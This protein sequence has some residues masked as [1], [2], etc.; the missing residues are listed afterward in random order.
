MGSPLAPILAHL[1]MSELEN[2]IQ[3]HRGKKPDLFYRYVDDIFMIMHG[4][5]KDIHSFLKFMNKIESSIKFTIEM[6][7]NNKLP[8]LDVMVE[9]TNTELITYVYRKPTDT[10]LYLRW[11][12]NQP[13]N[14]KINLIKCLCIRAKRIC[15]SDALLK[16]QLEYYKRIF[17]ANG[18][19]IN[20]LKKTIRGIELGKNIVKQPINPS[21]KKVFISMPYYGECSLILANKIKKILDHPLKQIVCGFAAR[22][23]ISTLF[24]GTFR[25]QKDMKKVIYRYDC[26]NCNGTYIGQTGR[27][28]EIRKEEH[29]KAFRG[30]GYSRIAEHCMHLNH[31]NNWTDI[32][33]AV[34]SNYIKRTIKESLLMDFVRIKK[35]K[36]VYSQK[37]FILNVF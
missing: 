9:R 7:N 22:T 31:E 36:D 34:E 25:G 19:P 1:F 11:T 4:N 15:S 37:S 28:V 20:V 32:I 33:I 21:I 29:K 12:S 24:S 13:R 5:Q 6:Q 27:G 3:D 35:G 10:G 17:T 2:C 18:Y 26:K 16:Q 23:R 30:R 8:F 14:Y